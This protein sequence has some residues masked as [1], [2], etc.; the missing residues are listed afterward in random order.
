MLMYYGGRIYAV[1]AVGDS[2]YQ[3]R[4]SRTQDTLDDLQKERDKTIEKLKEATRYNSTLKLLEK[5]GHESPRLPSTPEEG[6][7]GDRQEPKNRQ[8]L[9]KRDRTSLPSAGQRTGL[10]PPPTANIRRNLSVSHPSTPRTPPPQERP[11]TSQGFAALGAPS[12]PPPPP[13]PEGPGFHPSAFPPS[14]QYNQPHSPRWYDRV[15][16]VLLGEDETLPQNRLALI[17]ERCRLVNGQAAPGLKTLEEVGRWR[18]GG[19]GAWNGVETVAKHGDDGSLQRPAVHSRT[20]SQSM[21]H[22][23]HQPAIRVS[24]PLEGQGSAHGE[25][26]RLEG[27]DSTLASHSS[28]DESDRATDPNAR[29]SSI[30]DDES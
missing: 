29:A 9:K 17:C 6:P 27:E 2:W 13:Q 3:Y 7:Q 26:S 1:R 21:P 5:Y 22:P 8:H 4:I 23:A 10:A 25:E 19:C 30:H 15:L 28:E 11:Q 16:D 18:C 14:Q 20:R 24:S 12:T